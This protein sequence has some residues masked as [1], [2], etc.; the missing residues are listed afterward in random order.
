M[1]ESLLTSRRPDVFN[2]EAHPFKAPAASTILDWQGAPSK[3][4]VVPF[5]PI[6]GQLP[7]VSAIPG[8]NL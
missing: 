5:T 1:I 2:T 6:A 4:P 8:L 7:K 3:T